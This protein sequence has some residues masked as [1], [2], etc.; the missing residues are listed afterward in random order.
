[1]NA[2]KKP[3]TRVGQVGLIMLVS[4]MVVSVAA[5]SLGGLVGL[6]CGVGGFYV[7]THQESIKLPGGKA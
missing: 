7:L 2:K 3:L 5:G 4:G 1:M 6:L